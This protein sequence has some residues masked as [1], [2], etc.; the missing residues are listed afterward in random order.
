MQAVSLPSL[1]SSSRPF[2]PKNVPS[3]PDSPANPLVI[4]ENEPSSF[5]DKENDK[6]PPVQT[7]VQS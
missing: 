1:S 7:V 5:T 2:S 6:D 4:Q 3:G